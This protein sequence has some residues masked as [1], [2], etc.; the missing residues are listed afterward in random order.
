MKLSDKTLNILKSFS[1]INK[2]ILIR[3][4]KKISTVSPQKTIMA[5]SNVE[6]EF[7]VDFAIYELPRFLGVVSLMEDADF[8]FNQHHV[9]I[10]SG[11]QKVKFT[12]AD[13]QA[14]VAAPEKGLD[15]E[16]PDIEFFM[17]ATDF[18]SMIKASAVLELPEVAVVGTEGKVSIQAIDSKNAGADNYSVMVG[19]TED[20]F[21]MIFKPENLK[22]MQRSYNVRITSKG[23]GEFDGGDVKYWIATESNSSYKKNAS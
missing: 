18:M 15:I 6:E 22:L 13:P 1:G 2:S 16:D 14:V 11:Q 23:I 9:I 7:P 8:E 17:D 12:Y 21:R 4:G 10:S 19:K 20:E 3:K 5:T